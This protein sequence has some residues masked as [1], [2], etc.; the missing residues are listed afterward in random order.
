MR[1]PRTAGTFLMTKSDGI[2][3]KACRRIGA[4]DKPNDTFRMGAS[5]AAV[6]S[7]VTG[8]SGGRT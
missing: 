7:K 2:L 6:G 4:T 1:A 5:V 8:G 3:H